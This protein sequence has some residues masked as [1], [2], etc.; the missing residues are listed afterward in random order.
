MLLPKSVSKE[1]SRGLEIALFVRVRHAGPVH[2]LPRPLDRFRQI[3]WIFDDT[4]I[5][6]ALSIGA[7]PEAFSESFL[8]AAGQRSGEAHG[9][10]FEI[11]G[12]YD[13]CGS[14][15]SA[16]RMTM[17]RSLGCRRVLAAV[18]EDSAFRVKPID[19]H[20]HAVG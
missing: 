10:L 2:P 11:R 19:L 9:M 1:F 17:Q 15:P 13:K 5:D 3:D 4:G 18:E 12:F 7:Q 14:F 16:D 6:Q 20:D 8:R